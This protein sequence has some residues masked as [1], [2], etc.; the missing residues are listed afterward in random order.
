LIPFWGQSHK[1]DWQQY[2]DIGREAD[3]QLVKD[4]FNK[5]KVWPPTPHY[6]QTSSNYMS[7]QPA[8]ASSSSA[9]RQGIYSNPVQTLTRY[10]VPYT[11]QGGPP[12]EYAI[13]YTF[14]STTLNKGSKPTGALSSYSQNQYGDLGRASTYSPTQNL[15]T[16]QAPATELGSVGNT[17]PQDTTGL[18]KEGEYTVVKVTK[19]SHLTR[20]DEFVFSD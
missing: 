19:V 3:G 9:V 17:G 4:T 15:Y 12:G 5:M 20:P 13:T 18:S 11:T 10:A 8:S 16:S 2:K 14:Y 7:Y 1:G 6:S